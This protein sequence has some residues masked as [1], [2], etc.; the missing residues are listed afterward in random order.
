MEK[1][2][3]V[4][5]VPIEAGG[6]LLKLDRYAR[7][8]AQFILR[9]ETPITV[10]IQGDWGSGK[11]SLMNLV[12]S[13]L[14]DE[15]GVSTLEHLAERSGRDRSDRSAKAGGSRRCRPIGGW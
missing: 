5:D 4:R 15:G 8:L 11:S 14:D 13:L 6:D 2:L 9:C 12:R 10:G 7:S 3:G 1:T